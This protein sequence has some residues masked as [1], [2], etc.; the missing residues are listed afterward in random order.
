MDDHFKAIFWYIVGTTFFAFAYITVITFMPIPK[1]NVRFADTIQGFLLGTV[2]AGGIGYL[3]GG[4]PSLMKKNKPGETTAE[5]SATITT[6][7]EKKE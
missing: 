2:V 3:I 5:V 1:E 7:D 6:T 4:S